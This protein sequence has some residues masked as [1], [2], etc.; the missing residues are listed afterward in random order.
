[1]AGRRG[2]SGK[3]PVHAPTAVPR[4]TAVRGKDDL[5]RAIHTVKIAAATF[6]FENCYS[7]SVLAARPPAAAESIG[8]QSTAALFI[9]RG[10][11]EPGRE[12]EGNTETV[13]RI[14]TRDIYSTPRRGNEVG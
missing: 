1:M 9:D 10:D 2:S 14:R 5:R 11:L 8:L 13:V 12:R 4:Q 3:W 6:A 7:Y